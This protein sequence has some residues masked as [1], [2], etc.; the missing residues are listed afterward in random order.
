VT[1]WPMLCLSSLV[2]FLAYT[3][4]IHDGFTVKKGKEP[5]RPARLSSD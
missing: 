2:L 1:R 3:S 5:A 4:S